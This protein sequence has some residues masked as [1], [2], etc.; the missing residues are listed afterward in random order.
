MDNEGKLDEYLKDG[1][2]HGKQ[3]SLEQSSLDGQTTW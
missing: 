1:E 3:S 2:E